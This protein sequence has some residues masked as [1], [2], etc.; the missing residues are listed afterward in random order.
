MRPPTLATESGAVGAYSAFD[1]T[2]QDWQ[3]ELVKW[4]CRLSEAERTRFGAGPGWNCKDVHFYI[5]RISFDQLDPERSA[6][7]NHVETRFRLPRIRS[8]C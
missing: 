2:M 1:D 3:D 5:G 7:L 8:R 6:A 4:R